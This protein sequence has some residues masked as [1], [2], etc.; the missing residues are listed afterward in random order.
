MV[1][2]DLLETFIFFSIQTNLGRKSAVKEF[3]LSFSLPFSNHK[4]TRIFTVKQVFIRQFFSFSFPSRPWG[5][6]NSK[7]LQLSNYNFQKVS[8]LLVTS[9]FFL[10]LLAQV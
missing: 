2:I 10:I 1:E 8:K 4:A 5:L 9:L 6:S 3:S 7:L